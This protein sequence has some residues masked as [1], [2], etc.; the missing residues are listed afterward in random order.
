MEQS[1]LEK[2]RN[3][4]CDE[5][6]K[7][8]ITSRVANAMQKVHPVVSDFCEKIENLCNEYSDELKMAGFALVMGLTDIT[9]DKDTVGLRII[10][11]TR[12]RVN[13]VYEAI[14]KEINE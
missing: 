10:Y 2:M 6:D 13:K 9:D 8:M 5:I 12:S 4:T 14:T 11:G 1:L 7:I 3:N